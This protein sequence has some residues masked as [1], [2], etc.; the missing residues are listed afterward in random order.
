MAANAIDEAIRNV[1]AVGADPSR[2]AILDNFSWG[3]PNT[4]E[5]LG[6][7]VRASQACHDVAIAYGTPFISGKDS[8]NNEF[9]VGGKRIR[10][11]H[12]LLVSALGIVADARKAVTMDL[13]EAGNVLYILGE[14]TDE[15]GGSHYLQVNGLTGGR[16][17]AVKPEKGLKTFM[18][19][20]KL[21]AAGLVR[22]CHDLSE[23][24]LAVAA[25][26]MAF[27]GGLGMKLDLEIPGR[28]STNAARLFAETPSRFLIEVREKDVHRLDPM[29]VGVPNAPV[30]SVTKEARLVVRGGNKTLVDESLVRLKAAWKGTMPW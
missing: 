3:D 12:T 18:A 19:L 23:G 14:T 2:I 26:E 29:L 30:G 10:I 21:I 20:H 25:A 5:T 27:A 6:A 24:G 11:P 17:P 16:V 15:W 1:V 28:A 7:L 8:L 13:K 22:S 4:P 9:R